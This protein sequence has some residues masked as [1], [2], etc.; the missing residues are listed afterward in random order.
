MEQSAHENF[1]SRVLYV[2]K[3][4]AGDKSEA[5]T[6]THRHHLHPPWLKDR[7]KFKGHARANQTAALHCPNDGI[8][9]KIPLPAFYIYI[10]KMDP[11]QMTENR[12]GSEVL[13]P[14]PMSLLNDRRARPTGPPGCGQAQMQLHHGY[15]RGCQEVP[16][17]FIQFRSIP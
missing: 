14:R 17:I 5:L 13:T 8:P 4:I 1:D 2:E 7:S 16:G 15:N 11:G 12:L 6:T 10:Y 9:L 3:Q